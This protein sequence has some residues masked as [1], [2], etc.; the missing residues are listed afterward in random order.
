[1]EKD[2]KQVV[3]ESLP[4]VVPVVLFGLVPASD[5]N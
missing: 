5:W 2:E 4:A 3:A 1:M